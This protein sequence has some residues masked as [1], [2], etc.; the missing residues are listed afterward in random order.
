MAARDFVKALEDT[1][2]IQLS[3]SGRVSGRYSSRPVWFVLDGKTLYLLPVKGSDTEW[4]KNVVKNPT[5]TLAAKGAKWTGKA[6]P[7]SDPAK[8]RDLV[9]R[10]REKY[11]AGE[12]KKYYSKLDVAVRVSL[13]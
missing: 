6:T 13:R 7:I 11:G 12:V 4:Y 3:V 1:E 5:V 8:V 10:F 9:E 2:E